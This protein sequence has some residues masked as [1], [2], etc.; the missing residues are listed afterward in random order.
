MNTPKKE[1]RLRQ[2]HSKVRVSNQH[3]RRMERRLKE[4]IEHRGIEVDDAL[5]Q[6]L[7]AT[8][9]ESSSGVKEQYPSGSFAQIFWE[10]QEQGSR[11][12][13]AK[14]MRWE[15]AMIRCVFSNHE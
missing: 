11:L 9:A 7:C 1:E 13:N 5:H 10:Q 2:L 8:M 6:D 14:S 12:K 15:P 4:A 3:I